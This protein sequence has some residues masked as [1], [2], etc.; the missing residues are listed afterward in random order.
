MNRLVALLCLVFLPIS[1]GQMNPV[2][3]TANAVRYTVLLMGN[4]AGFATWSHDRDGSLQLYFEFNDRGRGP[5]TQ[6]GWFSTR[7]G[8]R[9]ESN[10]LEMTT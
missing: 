9:C 10:A 2:A 3:A 5:K 4:K 8:C 7:T 6:S 1:T